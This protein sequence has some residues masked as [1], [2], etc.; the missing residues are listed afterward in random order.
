[1]VKRIFDDETRC[2]DIYNYE[3]RVI[4]LLIIL[5]ASVLD[6]LVHY[7]VLNF[8][9]ILTRKCL[10]RYSNYFLIRNFCNGESIYALRSRLNG[11]IDLT[12]CKRTKCFQILD[13]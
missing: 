10:E 13:T 1:M 6:L 7:I 3:V 4:T 2:W 11:L 12:Y 5:S 9:V 8:D